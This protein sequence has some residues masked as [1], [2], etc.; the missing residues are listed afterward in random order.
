MGIEAYYHHGPNVS[1]VCIGAW[2]EEAIRK[3]ESDGGEG[4]DAADQQR[5][6]LLLGPGSDMI[7]AAVKEQYSKNLIDKETGRQVQVIEQKVEVV[8][9]TLRAAMEKYPNAFHE[10]L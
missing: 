5:P 10:R 7:P 4:M 9:P 6:L 1:A 3:Q 8:D 2:P